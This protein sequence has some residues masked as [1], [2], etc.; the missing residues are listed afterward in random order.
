[1]ARGVH[2]KKEVR[3][4][5]RKLRAAGWTIDVASGGHSHRWGTAICPYQHPESSGRSSRCV[6]F[7]RST[8]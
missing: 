1:M 3:K 6:H 4:A 5:L 7:I 8:P 2:P